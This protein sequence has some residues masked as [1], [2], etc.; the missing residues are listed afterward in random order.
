M[1]I[2]LNLQDDVVNKIKHLASRDDF[3]NQL[4]KKALDA[5]PDL[6]A[7]KIAVSKWA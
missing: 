7:D 3:V 1:Q 5:K 6:I 4:I 2:T